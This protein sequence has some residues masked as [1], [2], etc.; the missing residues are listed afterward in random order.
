M[1]KDDD[2]TRTD[3]LKLLVVI[4]LTAGPI[5]LAMVLFFV[6]LKGGTQALW[7]VVPALLP[8]L[9]P[10]IFTV[11]LGVLAG[12][13]VGFIMRHLGPKDHHALAEGLI[14][15][16]QVEHKGLLG[17]ILGALVGL[18]AGASLGPEGPLAHM[19]GGL[20]S[21]VGK[22]LN[23]SPEKN[24]VLSASGIAA[25]FGGFMGSPMGGAFMS[26]EF[27][28]LL[29]FP[30][31]A[32]LVAGVIAA[33]IGNLVY[34]AIL[35]TSLAGLYQFNDAQTLEPI[36][37]LYAFVLGLVG[38]GMAFVFKLAFNAM[39]QLFARLEGKTVLKTTLGGLGFGLIGAFLPLTL[40][41]GE[42]QLETVIHDAGEIGVAVLI[43]LA[44][45]KLVSLTLCMAS[46]FPGGFIFPVLFSA[47]AFGA[48]LHL[49]FPFVPQYVA[50]LCLMA[51]MGGALL[52]MPFS[53]ILLVG[54][55]SSPAF[56]PILIIA[57]F[58]GFL[59]AGYLNAG[60]AR[61]AYSESEGSRA[62]PSVAPADVK[63]SVAPAA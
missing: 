21:Y 10:R 38:V 17:L 7:S 30:L 62:T 5:A 41:S 24:R 54:L 53:T 25:I 15:D 35:G 42:A 43:V 33:L 32:S 37:L 52:R 59:A 20:A 14:R 60:S 34:F 27:T 23:F 11:L 12:I 26:V 48:A 16:G 58:T 46:G 4:L 19:G 9:D 55:I 39:K 28:G 2:V 51:G 49:V 3:Y 18:A 44:L 40:F 63:P 36:F 8:G 13:A 50:V 61:Q 1:I 31:Y 47:G 56:I 22:R 57:A 29:R 6:V 45:M